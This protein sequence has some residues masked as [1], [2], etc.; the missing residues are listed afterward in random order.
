MMDVDGVILRGRSGGGHWS[1]TLEADLGLSAADLQ[2]GFFSPHWND[3]AVGRA[4]LVERLSTALEI[5]APHLPADRLIAYWFEQD[6]LIDYALLAEI[7]HVRATGMQVHLATN[8]EHKRAAYLMEELGLARYVD[9]IHYSAALGYQKPDPEFFRAAAAR[10]GIEPSHLLLV[11]D[12][13][14]HIDGAREA[15]WH[16]A[17]WTEGST[18]TAILNSRQN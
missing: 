5:I 15:G 9:A 8:Q 16:A 17:L 10:V 12:T 3:V 11:D 7:E 4:C 2:R 13:P 14:A 18:L 6:S 1:A